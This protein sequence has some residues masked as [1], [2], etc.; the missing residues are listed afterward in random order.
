MKEIYIIDAARTAI[1]NFGG[2]LS[3]ISPAQMGATVVKTLLERNKLNGSEVDE[4]LMGS[5]LQAGHG[6]NVAR[7]IAM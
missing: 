6:Q 3:T 2:T 7:Q 4:V 1:G 5:V